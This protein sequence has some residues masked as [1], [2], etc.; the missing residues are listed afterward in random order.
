MCV[1]EAY[2]WTTPRRTERG[3]ESSPST[4]KNKNKKKRQMQN[5]EVF[6]RSPANGISSFGAKSVPCE[7]RIC[8]AQGRGGCFRFSKQFHLAPRVPLTIAPPEGGRENW[9]PREG[10]G[11]PRC[12]GLQPDLTQRRR[13]PTNAHSTGSRLSL[14]QF[15]TDVLLSVLFFFF[16]FVCYFFP[17]S[18]VTPPGQTHFLVGVGRCVAAED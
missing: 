10:L 12:E 18:S 8:S 4:V 6:Q 1:L 5:A 14:K 11:L 13:D 17:F 3:K 16:F 7:G 15:T 2:F 9:I